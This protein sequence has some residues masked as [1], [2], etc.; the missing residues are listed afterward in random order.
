MGGRQGLGM[1]TE[2]GTWERGEHGYKRAKWGSPVV[3]KPFGIL[4]VV[5]DTQ[6]T[7]DTFV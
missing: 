7:G 6:T 5:I 1:K 2:G 3:L 4:A